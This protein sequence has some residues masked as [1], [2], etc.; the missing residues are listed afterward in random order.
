MISLPVDLTF[1]NFTSVLRSFNLPEKAI[2]AVSGGRD[3]MVL[4]HQCAI[5]AKTLNIHFIAVTIDHGLREGSR[6]EAQKA[7]AWCTDLGLT[8]EVISWVHPSKGGE[9]VI[10]NGVQAKARHARYN[11]LLEAAE[12]HGAGVI[13]TAHTKTDLA[14]TVFMRL[15]RGS[16][17][18]GLGGMKE[19][20]LIA[21]GAKAPVRL[22]RPCLDVTREAMTAFAKQNDIRFIDDPSNDNPD[23]ERI[24]V[25]GLLSG[26]ESQDLLT[27][28]ALALTAK[29]CRKEQKRKQ[30]V[31]WSLLQNAG[32]VFMRWGGIGFDRSRICPQRDGV[33]VARALFAVGA[34]EHPPKEEDVITLTEKLLQGTRNDPHRGKISLGG[35]IMELREKRLLIYREPA[36]LYGRGNEKENKDGGGH[37]EARYQQLRHILLP[38]QKTLWDRRF[39]VSNG[40]TDKNVMVSLR[41]RIADNDSFFPDCPKDGL[42]GYPIISIASTSHQKIDKSIIDTD[43][44]QNYL[45]LESDRAIK[46]TCLSEERFKGEVLRF[47]PLE[48]ANM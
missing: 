15:M 44:Y 33:M 30:D 40:F 32:G 20:N 16:G 45:R 9:G 5:T 31:C 1:D 19:E 18:D 4:A 2:L 43:G 26:L 24:K 42:A 11:L 46:I 37:E 22:I 3:S 6:Q 13:L 10:N 38:G 7:H 34:G 17:V 41:P 21:A 39:I 14:E 27:P 48:D 36:A 47:L 8:H 23:F 35:A 29:R 28:S 12:R 25:R